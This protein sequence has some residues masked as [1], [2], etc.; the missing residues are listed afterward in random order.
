[1]RIPFPPGVR[2]VLALIASASVGLAGE[3][4]E[5]P[6]K[7]YPGARNPPLTNAPPAQPLPKSDAPQ[8]TNIVL[9][10]GFETNGGVGTN[11]FGDWIVESLFGGV[12]DWLVQT[13]VTSPANGF[14]VD[15]PPEGVFAAM[16]DQNGPGTHILHQVLAVPPAGVILTCRVFVNNQALTYFN[17]G[18]LNFNVIPNQH[19]RIDI[20]NPAAPIDDVGAGVLLNVFITNPGAPALIPYMAVTANLAPFAGTSVRLRI[21]EVDNQFFMNVGVDDCSTADVPVELMGFTIE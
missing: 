7:T 13:G 14:P 3:A 1:M 11:V 16:T 18:T 12:G 2:A 9:N 17:A 6:R 8:G 5:K 21:A 20:M 15:P 19:T 4:A 10:G